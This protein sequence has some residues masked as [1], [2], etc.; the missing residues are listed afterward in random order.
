MIAT[1]ESENDEEAP[2]VP[3]TFQLTSPKIQTPSLKVLFEV[4]LQ[5]REQ[6]WRIS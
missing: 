4:H 1:R 3:I 6:F 2:G 5:I